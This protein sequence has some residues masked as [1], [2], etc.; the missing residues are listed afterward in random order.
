MGLFDN[1]F[2]SS[3]DKWMDNATDEELSRGYEERRQKW[4]EDG[5]G[6]DGEK[7]LEMKK[8]DE[9]MS[10][11]TEEKWKNDPERNDDTNFRW[12]DKNRWE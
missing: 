1:L 11:R 5:F 6:G 10:R 4:V 8:I 2:K 3:F 12:T 7:T 9:E